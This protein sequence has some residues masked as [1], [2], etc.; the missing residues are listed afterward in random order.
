ME[1]VSTFIIGLW[2]TGWGKM[3]VLTVGSFQVFIK[4]ITLIVV[5]QAKVH[6]SPKSSIFIFAPQPDRVM[7]GMQ[8]EVLIFLTELVLTV[9]IFLTDSIL[10]VLIFLTELDFTAL[11]FCTNLIFTVLIF[12][13]YWYFLLVS[14]LP[15]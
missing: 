7:M 1:Q 4:L 15:Y 12:L 13:L 9:L 14:F 2:Q 3:V 11:I 8:M 5:L 10:T 6:I